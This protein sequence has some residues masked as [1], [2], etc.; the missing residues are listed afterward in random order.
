MICSHDSG[1]KQN[2]GRYLLKGKAMEKIIMKLL[3]CS[4]MSAVFCVD[5]A[6]GNDGGEL[7]PKKMFD[8]AYVKGDLAE[9]DWSKLPKLKSETAV[10]V[11]GVEN[12]TG[13][14]LHSYL[15]RYEGKF[16]LM[17]SCSPEHEGRAGQYLRYATSDDGIKWD[18]PQ[19]LAPPDENKTMR[20]NA[21]GFWVRDNELLALG[22]RGEEGKYFGPSLELRCWQWNKVSK[23]WVYKG[24]V[25]DKAINNFPPKQLD[26]GEWMMTRRDCD[27]NISVLIGGVES[28]NDWEVVD[29]KARQDKSK[30][31][32]PFWW[33]LDNGELVMGF[34]DNSWSKK[35]YRAFGSR[36]GREWTP[37]VRSNFP[38]AKA[39]F[40]VFK[41][42]KGDYV[43]VNNPSPKGRIPLCLS[44]SAD[45]VTF[46]KMGVLKGD[47]TQPRYL[48]LSDKW[49]YNSWGYNYPHIMEHAGNLFIAYARNKEDIEVLKV[50]LSEIERLKNF[51][52]ED[53]I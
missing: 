34:R 33:K 6:G 28:I 7:Q 37:P 51:T 47:P 25:F 43:L 27:K 16:W 40:N 44:V 46:T 5:P 19:T 24:V 12:V 42:S 38:D 22:S 11:R 4:A 8:V 30:M 31:A 45:G 14:N 17:W 21:R 49:R 13:F 41:T 3:C 39:K 9:F 32:E 35:L 48:E 20:Y 2:K 52:M 10:V 18:E 50:P 15:C 26:S 36:S 1:C 23:K 53:G 29:I